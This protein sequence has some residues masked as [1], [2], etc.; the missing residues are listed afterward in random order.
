MVKLILHVGLS[1]T[2]R[3]NNVAVYLV[4]AIPQ[5]VSSPFAFD[6]I[7]EA[8]NVS[9]SV[10]DVANASVPFYLCSQNYYATYSHC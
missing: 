7:C 5:S 3:R 2:S 1:K 6:I 9:V 4:V 10:G 8:A